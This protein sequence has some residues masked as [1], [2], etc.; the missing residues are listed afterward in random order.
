M[1]STGTSEAVEQHADELTRSLDTLRN[2]VLEKPEGPVESPEQ[3]TRDLADE[4]AALERQA[5]ELA[6]SV[7]SSRIQTLHESDEKIEALE[8]QAREF[9]AA[10]NHREFRPSNNRTGKSK[11]WDSKA[12][13]GHVRGIVAHADPHAIR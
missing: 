2:Q 3:P 8:L 13:F 6:R 11:R 1:E 4:I 10:S 9:G 12:R 7:E 5:R